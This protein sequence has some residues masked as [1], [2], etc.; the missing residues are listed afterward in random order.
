MSKLEFEWVLGAML[1][2][3]LE[4]ADILFKVFVWKHQTISAMIVPLLPIIIFNIVT[5]VYFSRKKKHELGNK[6]KTQAEVL[7]H[8]DGGINQ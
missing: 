7:R 6:D 3:T 8:E 1:L 5:Y 4:F 2:N